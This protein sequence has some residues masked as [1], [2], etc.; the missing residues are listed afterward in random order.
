MGPGPRGRWSLCTVAVE[1]CSCFS[2]T[3][4]VRWN[5]LLGEP[6]ELGRFLRLAPTITHAIGRLHERGLVHK[7]IKPANILLIPSPSESG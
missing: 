6:L 5:S 7:D 2:P 3:A 4:P 1:L